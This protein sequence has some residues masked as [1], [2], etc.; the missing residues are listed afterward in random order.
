MCT[1]LSIYEPLYQFGAAGPRINKNVMRIGIIEIQS[2]GI[3]AVKMC[4]ALGHKVVV[5][6]KCASNQYEA[7]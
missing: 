6:L 1:A 7:A 4:K 5:I 2:L 3:T